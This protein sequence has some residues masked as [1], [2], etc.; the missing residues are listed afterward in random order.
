MTA[1]GRPVRETVKARPRQFATGSPPTPAGGGGGDSRC[2]YRG[3]RQRPWGKWAAEIRDPT[4]ST[5]RWLGTFDTAEE[6][7][8]AYDAAALAIR[9]ATARTNFYYPEVQGR[10]GNPDNKEVAEVS[11]VVREKGGIWWCVRM[12]GVTR[13]SS[14]LVLRLQ[15]ADMNAAFGEGGLAA[16]LNGDGGDEVLDKGARGAR[17]PGT[18]KG[19]LKEEAE[20]ERE[21][22]MQA[23]G[24]ITESWVLSIDKLTTAHPRP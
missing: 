9:G 2:R 20:R 10:L 21:R 1:S 19:A 14:L 4:R 15:L 16:L 3:V 18:L 17:R 24:G 22:A 11:G 7:A 5:R 12:G 23:R 13:R 6:A 8:R